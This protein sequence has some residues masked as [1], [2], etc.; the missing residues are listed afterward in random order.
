MVWR[1]IEEKEEKNPGKHLAFDNEVS[2]NYKLL[3][4]IFPVF[5]PF[6][7]KHSL[8]FITNLIVKLMFRGTSIFT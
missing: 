1:T 4:I 6:Y 2:L 5:P 3:D 8:E 7:I